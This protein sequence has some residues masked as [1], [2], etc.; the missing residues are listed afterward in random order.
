M[1]FAKRSD[2]VCIKYLGHTLVV[3]KDFAFVFNST[4]SSGA[5]RFAPR[6]AGRGRGRD[7]ERGRERGRHAAAVNAAITNV[8]KSNYDDID[9]IKTNL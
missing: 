5:D 7:N 2:P 1:L 8:N 6:G 9:Y 3:S 4:K